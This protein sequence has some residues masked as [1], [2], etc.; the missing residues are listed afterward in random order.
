MG[1]YLARRLML[2]VPVIL[3]VIFITYALAIYGPGDPISTLI[4]QTEMR[5]DEALKERLRREHGFDRPFLVQYGD[6]VKNFVV[7]DWGTSFQLQDQS[8]RALVMRA[9][10]VSFQLGIAA[11][12]MLLLIGIPLGVWAGTR[13]GSWIDRS[14]LSFAIFADSI[15]SFVLAPIALVVF[16]LRLDLVKSAIGWDGLFSQKII[17]PAVILALGPMLIIVR[18]TR[19]AVAETLQQDYVRTA[20]AKGLQPSV[21]VWKHV[22]RNA[23]QPVVTLAGIIAA[24]MVTGSIF[25]EQIFGIPGFGQLV[26]RGL[27]RNDLPLL[28]ATTIIGAIFV[29]AANLF[30]DL[31]YALIDP[32]VRL[33]H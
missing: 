16:V 23:M 7:G 4:G 18:Q 25:I 20:R 29:I 11:F 8:V 5:D 26:V 24:Y 33:V 13:T 22:L 14:I 31:L 3:I 32:R 9:I 6:Y 30:V 12:A 19:Y 28:M 17:L 10:P 21:V 2:A 1:A 15:P 27:Q